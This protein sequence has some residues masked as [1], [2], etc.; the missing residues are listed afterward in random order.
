MDFYRISQIDDAKYK[1]ILFATTYNN[2]IQD[3]KDITKEL[4]EKILTPCYILFDLLNCNG[5][6]F[7]RFVEAYYDGE[8]IIYDSLKIVKINDYH[9]I[10]FI[11][12]YYKNNK[13]NLDYGILSS[14]EKY[15]YVCR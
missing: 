5:M 10:K 8:N 9:L 7:N 12:N 1:V 2:P 15:Q 13:R 6:S 3:L 4:G 14:R 11:D